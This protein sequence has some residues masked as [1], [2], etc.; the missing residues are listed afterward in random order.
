[1]S[2]ATIEYSDSFGMRFAFDT[3]SGTKK[4]FLTNKDCLELVG[5]I[6]KRLIRKGRKV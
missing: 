4:V 1:M 6:N 3:P 5:E 2:K